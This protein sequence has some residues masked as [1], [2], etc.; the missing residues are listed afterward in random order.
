[1]NKNFFRLKCSF[2]NDL[3]FARHSLFEILTRK[4]QLNSDRNVCV[5]FVRQVEYFNSKSNSKSQ[6]ISKPINWTCNEQTNFLVCFA[7]DTIHIVV[8]V[9]VFYRGLS[10]DKGETFDIIVSRR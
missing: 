8:V 5:F 9:V 1:M 10:L 6:S 4:I 7:L 2:H 3:T